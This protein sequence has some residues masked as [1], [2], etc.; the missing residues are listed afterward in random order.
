MPARSWIALAPQRA[1]RCRRRRRSR[2]RR[3]QAP[4]LRPERRTRPAV[5]QAPLLIAARPAP[6]QPLLVRRHARARAR[7]PRRRRRADVVR[8]AAHARARS[9]TAARR[10]SA[11]L[12][13]QPRPRRRPTCGSASATEVE[14][15]WEVMADYQRWVLLRRIRS[16]RQVHEVMTEFWENHFNVPANGDAA[17]TWRADFGDMIRAR[18]LGSLRRAAATATTHPAMLIDLDNVSSHQG[19]TPTR[20]SAASCSSCT[21]SGAAA[22]TR[23]R[24]QELRPDPHRLDR[25]DMW[26]DF[27]AKYDPEDHWPGP[28]T[29][30]G[31]H[32]QNADADGQHVARDYLDYLAAPP[33][34]ARRV[35]RKLAVKFVSDDPPTRWSTGWPGSTW[36]TTPRSAGAAGARARRRSSPGSPAQ[37]GPRPRRGHRRDV[38]RPGC[39]STPARSR[40]ATHRRDRDPLAGRRASGSKPFSWPRPDGQPIDNDSWSSPARMLSSMRST[41]TSCPAA[42][43]PTTGITYRSPWAWLPAR[44][45][46]GST[47]W[48]TSCPRRSCTSASTAAL[49]EAC[50]QAVGVRPREKIT[51]DHAIVRWEIPAPADHLPRLPRLL[52]PVTAMTTTTSTD[53]CCPEFARLSRRGLFTGAVALAGATTVD[54]LR[55]RCAPPR[56][57]PTPRRRAVL[58]VLSLR[59]AADGLSLV[60]PHADPVY[61]AAPP[62]D[63][64]PGGPAAV[65]DGMF[66]LHPELAPLLPLWSAGKLAAVHATGLPVAQPLALRGDGGGRGRQ[67]RLDRPRA[68]G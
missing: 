9:R 48:S 44:S 25:V 2:H 65:Q 11:A 34:T 64:R 52:P 27:S 59:G 58:V 29:V 31:F 30:L 6:R 17:F 45:R 7:G 14:C 28:V 15:G 4:P 3:L 1:R 68:A 33:A 50:C 26:Q 63:R 22:A 13:A 56:R 67:P 57:R 40:A 46:S 51:T 21:P 37:E 5:P 47:S 19:S 43:G 62:E 39:G 42:G 53:A 32:H 16:R 36:P 20:T 49:L 66:G 54:R 23:G 8:A 12:V 24:R 35:A 41:T 61:Y 10:R 60:V 55:R 18:A 38:P